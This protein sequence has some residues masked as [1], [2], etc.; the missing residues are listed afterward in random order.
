MAHDTPPIMSEDN[1]SDTQARLRISI[2]PRKES[3][4]RTL[5]EVEES[6]KKSLKYLQEKPQNTLS[7]A[8]NLSNI[9]SYYAFKFELTSS[10]GDL[11]EAIRLTRQALELIPHGQPHRFVVL[12]TLGKYLTS[13]YIHAKTELDL[14]EANNLIQL[15][16]ISATTQDHLHRAILLDFIGKTLNETFDTSYNSFHLEKA[17]EVLHESLA[18]VPEGEVEVK[19]KILGDLSLNL[20]YLFAIDD[21]IDTL[22]Q[23]IDVARD[24]LSN[25]PE[26]SASCRAL[27]TQLARF[28]GE[29]YLRTSSESD[30]DEA[31]QISRE[32][33]TDDESDDSCAAVLN[34][35]VRL[36]DRYYATGLMPALD[37]AIRVLQKAVGLTPKGSSSYPKTLIALSDAVG[38]RGSTTK[39]LN[40]LNTSVHLARE[41][42]TAV[43]LNSIEREAHLNNLAIQLTRLY[44]RERRI[45]NLKEAYK[46]SWEALGSTPKDHPHSAGNLETFG[47][48][49]MWRYRAIGIR[50]LNDLNEAIRISKLTLDLTPKDHPKR[51]RMLN[52]LGYRLEE[53][54]SV[55]HS[56]DD[57][58][59][60]IQAMRQAIQAVP[61]GRLERLQFSI[62]LAYML[63]SLGKETCESCH[64]QE[65]Q[66]YF[67]SSLMNESQDLLGRIVHGKEVVHYHAG[68]QQWKQ[69]FEATQIAVHLVPQLSLPHLESRDKYYSLTQIVGLSSDA[70]AI[71]L[72]ANEDPFEALCLLEHGR[73]VVAASFDELRADIADLQRQDPSLAKDFASLRDELQI[74]TGDNIQS[75]FKSD[76][77]SPQFSDI[78]RHELGQKLKSVLADIRQRADFADFMSVPNRSATM[79]AA[80]DDTIAAIN[81]S[82]YRC[83]AIIVQ[84]HAIR[85][86]AL[87]D[88]HLDDIKQ[89]SQDLGIRSRRVLE[90]LWDTVAGPIL[91]ALGFE[92]PPSNMKWPRIW[93]ILTGPLSQFPIHAAGRHFDQIHETVLDRARSSYISSVKVLIHGRRRKMNS[94]SNQAVLVAMEHTQEEARVYIPTRAR[95][96]STSA[97]DEAKCGRRTT[98]RC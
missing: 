43:P 33:T 82:K 78:R 59:E 79:A 77:P 6:I 85:A 36:H 52:N 54:Y 67:V 56:V 53:R 66:S 57:L 46:A 25:V 64:V 49:L 22:N 72:Q 71:A 92:G 27:S 12:L 26:E 97:S 8:I 31:I 39:S 61:E 2:E 18:I 89:K 44:T 60:A 75:Q 73:D 62:N 38:D 90:W 45:E 37:E 9:S 1:R 11:N 68:L 48:V 20:S 4:P 95:H 30:L 19:A 98:G 65:A 24:A 10:L 13:R 29:R 51:A 83:D 17:R 96:R 5:L 87:P 76:N 40:D 14:E 42:V 58:E 16:L 28:L 34:L 93:W 84:K 3:R 94:T 88:L 7:H 21:S 69:A 81:V 15:P 35:G 23:A 74:A 50:N 86:V 70:A 80:R 63:Q 47:N 32:T 91:T 41:S 55:S